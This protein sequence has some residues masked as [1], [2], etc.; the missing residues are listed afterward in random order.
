MAL[1]PYVQGL[2]EKLENVF[3]EHGVAVAH[4]PF[5]TL[6]SQLVR[7][8]DKT[9]DLKKCGV[10]YQVDCPRCDEF[11]IGETERT[12]GTRLK[13]HQTASDKPTA[14]REHTERTGHQVQDKDISVLDREDQWHRRR[15]REAVRIRR[16]QPGLNRDDG[17]KLAHV[18]DQLLGHT[19]H[20]QGHVTA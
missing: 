13:E 15:I 14:V 4:K 11:Y 2:S 5:N 1:V 17:Y 10:I 3:R 19:S 18:Y 12:L 6:R 16:F 7:V 9:P 8:K 20:D